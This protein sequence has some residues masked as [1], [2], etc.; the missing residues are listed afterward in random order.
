VVQPE[1]ICATYPTSGASEATTTATSTATATTGASL[2]T[3]A[4]AGTFATAY[5]SFGFFTGWFRLSSELN[6]DFAFEYFFARELSDSLLR[7]FSSLEVD[8][9][10]THW[11]ICARVDR[12]G[13]GFPGRYG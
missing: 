5:S 8:E 9:S 13:G 2:A 4:T 3:L 7:F 12:D 6:G 11:T 1:R 10:I